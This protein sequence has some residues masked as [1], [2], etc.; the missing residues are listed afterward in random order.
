MIKI[1][2]KRREADIPMASMSDIAFLLII[3]FITSMSF[4]YRQGIKLSLPL[5]DSS[6]VTL[7]ANTILFLRLDQEGNLFNGD[8]KIALEELIIENESAAIIK[9]AEKCKYKYLVAVIDSLRKK[10]IVKVSVKKL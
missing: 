4:L 6:P 8:K 1:K 5:K 3:F 2:R 7:A 10:D 9:V